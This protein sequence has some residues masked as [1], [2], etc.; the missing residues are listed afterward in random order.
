VPRP[1]PRRA[2][3]T[4]L[5]YGILQ[6]PDGKMARGLTLPLLS[7]GAAGRSGRY[8]PP[9]TTSGW[10]A[11]GVGAA[12][13]ALAL[14]GGGGEE[15]GGSARAQPP[16]AT[17]VWAAAAARGGGGGCVASAGAAAAFAARPPSPWAAPAGACSHRGGGGGSGG[18]AGGAAGGGGGGNSGEGGVSVLGL[19]WHPLRGAEGVAALLREGGRQ[20]AVRTV[21]TAAAPSS[22]SHAIFTLRVRLFPPNGAA[23]GFSSA[24]RAARARGRASPPHPLQ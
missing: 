10:G 13:V 19:S 8:A 5:A 22:R 2:L 20:R 6:G 24:P 17:S 7:G 3:G 14:I 12:R 11:A 4:A 23:G 1:P 18:G 21:D 9:P 16:E 15:G